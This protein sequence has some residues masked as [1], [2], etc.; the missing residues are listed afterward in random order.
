MSETGRSLIEPF[1]GAFGARL[2]KAR[3][4]RG[5]SV[6]AVGALLTPRKTGASIS[7]IELG[8]QRVPLHLA[9]E[10]AA[11]LGVDLGELVRPSKAQRAWEALANEARDGV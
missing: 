4:K 8:R 1:Y 10:L 6:A 2:R 11:A 7:N 9:V 5:L 3:H